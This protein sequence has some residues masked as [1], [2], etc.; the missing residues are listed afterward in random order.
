MRTLLL[1]LLAVVADAK[2][3]RG[4]RESPETSR[5]EHDKEEALMYDWWCDATGHGDS[6]I[7]CITREM[8]EITRRAHR[9][10]TRITTIDDDDMKRRPEAEQQEARDAM[11]RA[12]RDQMREG[13][14][15]THF[16]ETSG[17]ATPTPHI[18]V[19]DERR[20]LHDKRDAARAALAGSPRDH[21]D[22]EQFA[23]R[24]GFCD[25]PESK[26]KKLSICEEW[27]E[28]KKAKA[29]RAARMD[30]GRRRA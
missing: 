13:R 10:M 25:L 20:A 17:D 12:F 24:D 28:R 15:R 26:N 30:M 14:R 19:G 3:V 5:E 1:G 22:D 9:N 27:Q 23:M 7:A 4:T 6:S 16:R 8:R 11:A 18:F 2:N 29:E 21:K